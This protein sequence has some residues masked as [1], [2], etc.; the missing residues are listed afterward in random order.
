MLATLIDMMAIGLI[1]PV[2]PAL[3]GEFTGSQAHQAYWYGVVTFAFGLANFFG[4]PF[5]GALSDARG[6]RSVL[7]LGF[8]GMAFSFLATVLATALWVL[9]AVRVVSGAMQANVSVANAYV[10]DITPPE[11]RAK[12]GYPEIT[13][14]LRARIFGLNAAKP[15]GISAGEVK[16][17]ALSD[18]IAR[19][20]H[21][22]Q[23]HPE[24]HYLTYG[25]K[26]RREFLNLLRWNGGSHG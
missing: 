24:P 11:L 22:Y 8:C 6:R 26:T 23:G 3:V 9:I 4:S 7:L 17:R 2:L 12:H 16:K 20:R 15:Y 18:H 14:A 19:E 5:L 1:I 25:P 13:P 21:A 10:A